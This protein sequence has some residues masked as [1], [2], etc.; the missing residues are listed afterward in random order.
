MVRP[1]CS[2]QTLTSLQLGGWQTIQPSDQA[3]QPL[4]LHTRCAQAV[5]TMTCMVMKWSTSIHQRHDITSM[6]VEEASEDCE[7]GA[8]IRDLAATYITRQAS[9]ELFF[10]T[11]A[12]AACI[13]AYIVCC[14]PAGHTSLR[15]V[16]QCA[17]HH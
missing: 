13:A 8:G 12:Y 16:G 4:Q 17:R 14:S 15:L 11:L 10:I 6:G 3:P 5:N 7:I 2:A 9:A 1:F